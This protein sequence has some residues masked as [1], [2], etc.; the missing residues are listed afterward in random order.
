MERS[1]SLRLSWWVLGRASFGSKCVKCH[2]SSLTFLSY[3]MG[4]MG[5]PTFQRQEFDYMRHPGSGPKTGSEA[6]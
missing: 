2:V 4:A 1:N 5:D 3:K 6:G